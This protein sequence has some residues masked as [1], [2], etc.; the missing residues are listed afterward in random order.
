MICL[1]VILLV[2]FTSCFPKGGSEPPVSND[3]HAE[4]IAI[5]NHDDRFAD[6]NLDLLDAGDFLVWNPHSYGRYY[7]YYDKTTDES[8]ILCSK[9]ECV[10]NSTGINRECGAFVDCTIP[11]ISCYNGK[12][13]FVDSYKEEGKASKLALLRMNTDST[14]REFVK[15]IDIPENCTPVCFGIHRGRMYLY[16]REQTTINA[17]P[18]I[19]V[20]IFT[21]DLNGGGFENIYRREYGSYSPFVFL[22]YQ[23][24]YMYF[25]CG[26][27]QNADSG[28]TCEIN[29]YSPASGTV[30]TKLADLNIG[31]HSPQDFWV[32]DDG[33]FL[34]SVNS[35]N[36][37][38]E[39]AFIYKVIDGKAEPL[40][41]AR[42]TGSDCE[43]YRIIYLGDNAVFSMKL[44]YGE[45]YSG[46]W[47]LWVRSFDG[48]TIAKG[49]LPFDFRDGLDNNNSVLFIGNG[50]GDETCFIGEYVNISYD[51]EK[52]EQIYY[53]VRYTFNDGMLCEKLLAYEITR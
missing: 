9:P 50:G 45:N 52:G 1:L 38:D 2:F 13:Y 48:D 27:R 3:D 43:V 19:A 31:D 7:H 5:S 18:T 34:F 6:T 11:S 32:C 36:D 17:V 8:G 10:H 41:E 51:T 25:F 44:V 33:S 12:L 53:L 22:R 23:G 37:I 42:D 4:T 47:H 46:T 14:N 26:L 28:L 40:M 49:V 15:Y 16:A 39:P 35:D 29:R 20:N 30:D 21:S 24:E